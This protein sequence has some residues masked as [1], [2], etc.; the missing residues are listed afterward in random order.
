MDTNTKKTFCSN[1]GNELAG[2]FCANCGTVAN[3]QAPAQHEIGGHKVHEHADVKARYT[4]STQLLAGILGFFPVL[5]LLLGVGGLFTGSFKD[6]LISISAIAFC[7]ALF[8]LTCLP[9][10]LMI[11]KRA[12]EGMVI[13]TCIRFML[14]A[15]VCFWACILSIMACCFIIGIVLG[16]WRLGTSTLKCSAKD[17]TAFVDGKKISVTRIEDPEF[18]TLDQTRYIYIAE[19]GELYR[20]SIL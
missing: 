3:G 18:S 6:F 19:N 10:I 14:K 7:F 5:V 20:P 4:T 17:Y 13:K 2:N 9:G 8:F 15:A 12:P 11:R 16:A 1:C